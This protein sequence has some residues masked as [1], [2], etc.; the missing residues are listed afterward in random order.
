MAGNLVVVAD[1]ETDEIVS[2]DR[3]G[4]AVASMPIPGEKITVSR[5][6]VEAVTESLQDR[7]RRIA[8]LN[9]QAGFAVREPFDDYV[10]RNE[11]PPIDEIMVDRAGRLWVRRHLMPGDAMQH[12]T[13]WDGREH[14]MSVELPTDVALM[15]AQD[16]RVLLRLEDDLGVQQAVVRRIS[17]NE[18]QSGDSAR[19][20]T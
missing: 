8:E 16:R 20:P 2:Y 15:D 10:A 19:L 9:R 3:T 4:V 7:D 14:V 11:A 13:V 5:A 1:T 17:A 18:D 12:W 6:H